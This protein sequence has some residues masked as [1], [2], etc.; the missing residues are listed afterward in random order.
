[1]KI[2]LPYRQKTNERIRSVFR[3]SLTK[4]NFVAT[5]GRFLKNI[6]ELSLKSPC[7]HPVFGPPFI[8]YSLFQWYPQSNE[9]LLNLSMKC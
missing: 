9:I 7:L 4:H 8:P 1:M 3:G 2:L 5:E 6:L